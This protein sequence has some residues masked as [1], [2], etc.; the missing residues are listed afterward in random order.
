MAR[1]GKTDVGRFSVDIE[2]AN[3]EDVIDARRGRLDPAKIRRKTIKGL[4]DSGATRLI[5][6]QA[7]AKELGF[8][9]KSSKTR[10]RYADGRR[11]L[12]PEVTDVNVL[13]QGRDGIFT[14]LVEPKRDTALV[15]A[16][17]LEDLDFLVDCAHQR[18]VPRD[19]DYVISEAE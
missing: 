3:N 14:A 11:A 4:V 19:P 16:I 12:R 9:V 2:I 6:P 5:L 7:I 10:V 13:I 8:P 15:G 18:L 17:V 1:K